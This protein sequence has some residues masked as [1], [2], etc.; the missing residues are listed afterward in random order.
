MKKKKVVISGVNMV[1]S[2]ILS[3]YL[4]I[5]KAL[6]KRKD[7]KLVCLVNNKEIFLNVPLNNVK[8]IEY[9]NVKKKWMSRL[10]F[11]Y[12][13]SFY[14]SKRLKPDVWICLH[15]ITANVSAPKRFVYCHNPSPF[16][17]AKASDYRLD[18][19]FYLFSKF[20]KYLYR[21][22]ITK[23]TSVIV[24]Q[25]WIATK[26]SE[27]FKID[28]II[29]SKPESDE[30]FDLI[31]Q[32]RLIRKPVKLI[33]PAFPRVFKNIELLI[34]TLFYLKE[35]HLSYYND[36]EVLLTFQEGTSLYGDEMINKAKE[37]DLG[38]I[39]FCGFLDRNIIYEMYKN[40]ADALIFPSKLETWGLPI[41]EAKMFNLPI[42]V[43]DFEY[44]QET[45]GDYPFAVYFK[46]NAIELAQI[47][48]K[49]IDG[50]IDFAQPK[51]IVTHWKKSNTYDELVTHMIDS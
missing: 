33:Y 11:E 37:L 35:N 45:I 27:W 22:N 41:S 28:N 16:Y 40:D 48:M 34:D 32:P 19:K 39:K 44:S 42:M 2:G 13:T 46:N 43:A 20:Y 24:Q 49:F 12:V 30:K 5:A 51:N 29:V 31:S 9:P 26:F 1:D 7:V 8:F 17:K 14:I 4:E 6:S 50:Q 3:I 10:Y 38:N 21:I 25:S 47:I 23:N 36:L 18:K 15:D